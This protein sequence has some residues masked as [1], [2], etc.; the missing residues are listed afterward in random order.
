M[1]KSIPVCKASLEDI[2]KA[3]RVKPP[4]TLDEARQLLPEKVKDFAHLFADN[5]GAGGLP[6]NRGSRDHAINIQSKG[7]DSPMPPWGL[8]YSMSREEL[9]VLRKTLT[10]LL[11][12]GW[13][14]PCNSPAAAPVLFAR[15]PNGGLRLCVDYRGLNAITIPDRY[16]LP[17]FKETLRQLL[18]AKWFIKLDVK[19]AFH[20]IRIREGD[21]WMTAFRCRLG[22]FEWLVTPFGLANAPATFQRYINDQL[23]EHLDLNATAYMDDVLAYT[24]GSEEDRWNTV[25]SILSKLDKAGLY[26]DVDK[27]EFLRQEVKYLGY[28]I[29]A[30]ESITVDPFKVKTIVKWQAPTSVRGVRSFLGFANFYRC[31]IDGF[32][33]LSN[34]LVNL[35]KKTSEWKWDE[36]ENNSFEQLKK[37]SLQAQ[38]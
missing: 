19:S 3:L 21:E 27:C 13:I 9:L 36:E 17:L 10:D 24:S 7:G 23:R 2:N 22:L 29:K 4:M 37:I 11:K 30:G 25:R 1:V 34:P 16:P 38:Y 28:I 8:L 5:E 6:P 18:K 33:K 15:K 32:S 14:R 35:T 12:K 26:L 20:R 31:F